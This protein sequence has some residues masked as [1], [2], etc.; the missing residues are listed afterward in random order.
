MKIFLKNNFELIMLMVSLMAIF[1]A[2]LTEEVK[3][4]IFHNWRSI[5][6]FIGCLLLVMSL[7]SYLMR[8]MVRGLLESEFKDIIEANKTANE[9]YVFWQKTY[10]IDHLLSFENVIRL[11]PENKDDVDFLYT[12]SKKNTIKPEE[13]ESYKLP[14]EMANKIRE[15]ILKEEL[16]KITIKNV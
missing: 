7:V 4:L 9:F 1:A 6:F 8:W 5:V 12:I 3:N 16:E 10:K 11:N 14:K 2:V 13:W 15:R